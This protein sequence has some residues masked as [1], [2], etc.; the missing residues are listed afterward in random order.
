M[1]NTWEILRYS[2]NIET[3]KKNKYQTFLNKC[4]F[5]GNARVHLI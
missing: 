2:Y 1:N 5:E 4:G 3:K